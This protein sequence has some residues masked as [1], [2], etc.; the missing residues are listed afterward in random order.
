M[1]VPDLTLVAVHAHPDDESTSTGGILAHYALEGVRTIVVTCTNGELGD[2]PDGAKP[3]DSGH[4]PEKVAATR[5]AELEAACAQLG[6]SHVELLGYHDS[7]MLDWNY[8]DRPDVFCNV[9]L[10]VV[11]RRIAAVFERFRPQVVVTYDPEGTYQHPDH[12]HAARATA[13]A[14]QTTPIPAKLYFK[15]NGSTYWKGI[16]EALSQAGIER[17]AP[18]GERL[19]VMELVEQRITTNIDVAA[20]AHKKRQ[21]LFAHASQLSSSLAA[22]V[23]A[24]LFQEV[25][26]T[27]SFTRAYDKTGAPIPE[28]DLFAGLRPD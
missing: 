20:V 11:A 23:P 21:A 22:K 1:A 12:V 5:L 8:K 18:T 4:D 24:T 16:R 6:V 17:P 28:D 25:F 2:S 3:G 27:E 15:A 14:V 10:E 19:R 26:G 13:L 9:P 7:G